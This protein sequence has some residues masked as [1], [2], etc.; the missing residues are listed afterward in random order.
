[1][2]K[3]SSHSTIARQWEMLRILPERK[4]GLSTG[5][6]HKRLE[7][8][9]F[10]VDRRTV[11]RDLGQLSGIF[12]LETE[13]PDNNPTWSWQRAGWRAEESVSVADAISLRLIEEVL[14]PLLPKSILDAVQPRMALARSKLEQLLTE[15]HKARWAAKVAHV[16]PTLP[17]VPPNIAPEVL[18][19]VQDALLLERQIRVHYRKPASGVIKDLVLHPLGMVQRGAITYLVATTFHYADV[20]LYAMHRIQAVEALDEA[21]QPPVDFDLQAYIDGGALHFGNGHLIEFEAIVT[22]GLA[23]MLREAPL[24]DDQKLIDDGDSR[25]R[26]VATVMDSWQFRWWVLQQT[27]GLTVVGPEKLREETRKVLQ[28][29]IAHYE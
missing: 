6:I 28:E 14:K 2:S 21:I 9:G 8:A 17:L 18:E 5:D 1:M 12:A 7:M 13:G 16:S 15:N 26:V 11:Q 22:A 10:E 23:E 29:A 4:P 25:C 3:K 24:S 20:L 19:T 27:S